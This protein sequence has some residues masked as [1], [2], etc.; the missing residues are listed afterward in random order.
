MDL[1]LMTEVKN[2]I[3]FN[4]NGDRKILRSPFLLDLY[5]VK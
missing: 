3:P 4:K 5:S 2:N 1:L